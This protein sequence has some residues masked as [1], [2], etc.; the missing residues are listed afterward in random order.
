[1]TL[2][3]IRA[4]LSS[5][6]EATPGAAL[7]AGVGHADALAPEIY[8]L[9]DKLCHGV[10]LVPT[11][12]RLLFHGLH[13]L[14][15]ARQGELLACLLRLL[16]QR[17]ADL[18]ELF[19]DHGASSMA[20]LVLSV[21]DG[22]ADGLF[23]MLEHADLDANSRWALFDVLARLTFDGRIAR[24]RTEAFLA[25]YESTPL[26][27]DDDEAWWAWEAAVTRLGLVALEPAI[28]RSWTKPI[29]RC[30][31]DAD[32]KAS[33]AE[34]RRTAASP[35]DPTPFI[36]AG[37]APVDDPVDG[38]VWLA[39]RAE[40]LERLDREIE[41]EEG[42]LLE[43]TD[44]ARDV[45]LTAGEQYWLEGFL[46]SRH[47]PDTTLSFEGLDGFFTALVIGPGMVPPSEYLPELWGSETGEGPEWDSDEQATYVLQLLVKHWNA[48]AARR[49]A[50]G[51]MLPLMDPDAGADEVGQLWAEGFEVGL[52]MRSDAWLPIFEHKR[53]GDTVR[54]VLGLNPDPEDKE[55]PPITRRQRREAVEQLP[56]LLQRMCEFWKDPA[57][58]FAAMQ[59]ARSSKVG[60][61]EPCP[62]GSGKKYKRC[63]GGA[64]TVH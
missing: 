9:A 20:Q 34:L 52:G 5:S 16:R 8:A 25:R 38:I 31:S 17:E 15:A 13:V 39:R 42:P 54:I 10:V 59:P 1:M 4:D 2:D 60:R 24:E 48:I 32:R 29:N 14:A 49:M 37:I 57:A 19:P 62:C 41:A 22:D 53:L 12:Q 40:A 64:Q 28:V 47:V 27:D 46:G 44:P 11:Q 30:Q 45:R 26:A 36:D 61:N 33:L 50:G 21:W 63:C 56:I 55:S 23:R 58:A 3:D 7:R 18:D 35:S 6:A 43:D 51:P